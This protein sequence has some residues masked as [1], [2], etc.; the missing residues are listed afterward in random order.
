MTTV[1]L[2][3]P[4]IPRGRRSIVEL[5]RLEARRHLTGAAL[6]L[7][8][9]GFVYVVLGTLDMD[10]Q[11]SVYSA[12][13]RMFLPLAAATFVAA[14]RSG[15][16]DRHADLPPLAEDAPL[17]DN[18]RA[19]ARLLGL[20]P[21]LAVTMVLVIAIETG[22]RIEGGHWMGNPPGRTDTAVHTIPELLQPI[23]MVLLGAAAGV[24]AGRKFRQRAPITVLGLILAFIM[25][26]LWWAFQVIPMAYVTLIQ[27]QPVGEFA[28]SA[29][30]NPT[31]FPE[32]WLLQ[33]DDYEGVWTRVYVDQPMIA[34]HVV[35][36]LG[37][38]A[39]CM[40]GVVRGRLGRRWLWIGV[41]T[42]AL[43]LFV[44][45]AATGFALTPH[46]FGPNQIPPPST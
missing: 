22:I 13:P 5:A 29:G 33:N 28:G 7:G 10:W 2:A 39:V 19:I 23:A 37:V 1:T 17:D 31:T 41:A 4:A 42:V 24:A 32:H 21:F 35:Y 46:G 3:A 11:S 8:L 40:A 9:L 38:A 14:I 20:A 34:G 25:G 27:T 45:L 6:W 30:T 12:F 16:R 15:G 36:L 44:Q 43:G 26:M 18:G